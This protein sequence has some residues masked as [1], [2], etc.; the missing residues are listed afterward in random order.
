MNQGLKR[1]EHYSKTDAFI[2]S[3]FV[4]TRPRSI[5]VDGKVDPGWLV[6]ARLLIAVNKHKRDAA[7]TLYMCLKRIWK[8]QFGPNSFYPPFFSRLCRDYVMIGLNARDYWEHLVEEPFLN[9][10]GQKEFE[11]LKKKA[12]TMRKLKSSY[13]Y[14]KSA[15][16]VPRHSIIS[17]AK[18][19]YEKGKKEFKIELEEKK[20][21]IK[22]V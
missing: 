19:Y 12:E 7:L 22:S 8:E 20:K 16:S 10:E 15:H 11:K 6:T 5:D 4:N 18:R 13:K 17:R 1:V 21:K 9:T 2:F 14:L 3:N